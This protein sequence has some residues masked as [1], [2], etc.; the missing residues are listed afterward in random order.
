[1]AKYVFGVDIGG[2]NVLSVYKLNGDGFADEGQLNYTF[3]DIV[4]MNNDGTDRKSVV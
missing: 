4:D 2:N 1:M 3:L